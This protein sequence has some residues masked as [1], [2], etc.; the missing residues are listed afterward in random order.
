MPRELP[1]AVDESPGEQPQRRSSRA[2]GAS[3]PSALL[4]PSPPAGTPL[5]ERTFFDTYEGRSADT[6]DYIDVAN[7]V[8]GRD[9]TSYIKSW[10]YGRT[11]PPTPGHQDWKPGKPS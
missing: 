6:Q 4:G 11:T 8:S 9:L 5:I 7:R 10:I 1:P 3:A 2:E